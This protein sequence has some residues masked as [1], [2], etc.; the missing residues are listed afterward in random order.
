MIEKKKGAGRPAFSEKGSKPTFVRL[1]VVV[2][3]VA[4]READK[5]GVTLSSFIRSA[6]AR[7]VHS[8]YADP[9]KGG[10]K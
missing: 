1:P 10:K 8:D 3:D 6:V 5:E 2:R 9:T 7:A 4:Q